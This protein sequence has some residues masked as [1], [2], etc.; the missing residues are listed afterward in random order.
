MIVYHTGTLNTKVHAS[1]DCASLR[2]ATK[3]VVE[4]DLKD[5]QRPIPCRSC[6]S[7]Y[8]EVKVLHRYCEKCNRGKT[9]PCSHNGGVPVMVRNPYGR[10]EYS[11]RYV[12]PE[13]AH[14][15][16][17]VPFADAV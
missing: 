5:V 1:Q 17:V 4:T 6:F 12:W 3:P 7:G 13:Q 9:Y 11:S 15:Y 8:P 2:R 14:H 16:Q 10:R